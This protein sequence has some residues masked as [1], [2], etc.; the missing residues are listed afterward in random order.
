[1]IMFPYL[2]IF[3]KETKDFPYFENPT[4]FKKVYSSPWSTDED[5]VGRK[6]PQPAAATGC[7]VPLTGLSTFLCWFEMVLQCE[8]QELGLGRK[9]LDFVL[10]HW[11]IFHMLSVGTELAL[12]R[13]YTVAARTRIT[14]SA[15]ES[16]EGWNLLPLQ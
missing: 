8:G 10:S 7:Q 13:P 11:G 2:L 6:G 5:T 15:A 1:M 12:I 16:V 9:R 4:Q 14:K 3:F